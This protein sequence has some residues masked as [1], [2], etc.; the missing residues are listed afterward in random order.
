MIL[1]YLPALGVSLLQTCWVALARRAHGALLLAPAVAKSSGLTSALPVRLTRRQPIG[2][3][4]NGMRATARGLQ[5]E[6]VVEHR[7]A[8][9][10]GVDADQP[11]ER[12]LT[13][14]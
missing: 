2:G 13:R 1:R 3:A 11:D 10:D 4:G 7:Q 12:S 6:G 14:L 8:V 5:Q 9:G